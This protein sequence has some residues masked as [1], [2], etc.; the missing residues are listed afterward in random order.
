MSPTST[1]VAAVIVITTSASGHRRAPSAEPPIEVAARPAAGALPPTAERGL[2]Y[3]INQ[4]G[5]DGGWGQGGGWR[6]AG[7]SGRVEQGSD[8][9]DVGNTAV[10]ALALVRAG[11]TPKRGQYGAQ[12]TKA[13][14]FVCTSVLKAEPHSLYVT[15]IRDTQIQ[16]KIGHYVDTFLTSLFLSEVKGEMPDA[17]GEKRLGACLDRVIAKIERNQRADGTFAGNEGWASTL[18]QGIATK[19]LNTARG[20]GAKVSEEA[21]S[22]AQ[23]QATSSYD[24]KTGRFAPTEGAGDAGI[25]LYGTSAGLSTVSESLKTAEK[26]E[27]SARQI[28]A[29]TKAP[30]KD[31]A[32]ARSMLDRM[33]EARETQRDATKKLVGQLADERFVAG[34]GSNGGE[35]FLSYLNISE[36]LLAQNDPSFSE[37]NGRMIQSLA[38]VQNGDGS[39]A[40]QHCITGRTFVTAAALLVLTAD[41]ANPT[42]TQIRRG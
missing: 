30:E 2:A 21:L 23:K 6:Q 36:S 38:R 14:D 34:F 35:E 9:S 25:G 13:V 24:N 42:S 12:V 26:E 4:Q 20:K 39:W 15:D 7:A 17:D 16:I 31:R 18:S 41:R 19:G 37:W 40:G 29:D 1:I 3:L 28:A 22:R 10:A 11:H 8:R 32:E 5:K 27:A 33:A